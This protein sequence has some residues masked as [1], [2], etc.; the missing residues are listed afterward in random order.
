MATPVDDWI[1]I[2]RTGSEVNRVL[3]AHLEQNFAKVAFM[4]S[5]ELA[6]EAGVSQASVTRFA[7]SLGYAG[8]SEWSKAL[9]ARIRAELSGPE[10]LWFADH[11]TVPDADEPGDRVV[12]SEQLQLRS[13]TEIAASSE[14]E[15]LAKAIVQARRVVFVSARASATLVPYLHYF[16]SKLRPAVDSA[17]PGEPLWAQ[18]PLEDPNGTLVVGLAF[19][20]YPRVL[21]ERLSELA[22]RGFSIAAVTDHLSSPITQVASPVVCV[23]VTTVSLFD[24][25]ATPMTLFNLLIRRIA[26]LTPEASAAR[27]RQIEELDRM[28]RTYARPF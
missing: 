18:L 3:G 11:P 17:V 2:S 19:P 1:D 27:L 23:P 21:M 9:Q 20:R 16:L 13:L 12:H 7:V 15:Q 22:Q 5:A 8:F 25:Y 10:R 24:S 6:A 14:F 26:Q 4:T 28:S